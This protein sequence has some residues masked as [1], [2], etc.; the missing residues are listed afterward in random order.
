MTAKQVIESR[1]EMALLS[2]AIEGILF[3]K[4]SIKSQDMDTMIERLK[5]ELYEFVSGLEPKNE[6]EV[7]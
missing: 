2:A 1:I 6:S 7:L 4:G 5:K 3:G